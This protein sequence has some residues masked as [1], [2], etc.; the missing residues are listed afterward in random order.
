M[1]QVGGRKKVGVGRKNA[2]FVR[3]V[4]GG[5]IMFV[6]VALSGC[7]NSPSAQK[8]SDAELKAAVRKHLKRI[9]TPVTLSTSALLGLTEGEVLKKQ[10]LKKLNPEHGTAD[11][12]WFSGARR[13]PRSAYGDGYIWERCH[14]LTFENG[15]VVKHEMVDRRTAHVSIRPRQE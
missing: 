1:A 5:A 3:K 13:F 4:C 15:K 2:P 10:G 12:K 14:I 6:A 9:E 7:Q 11:K 8:P